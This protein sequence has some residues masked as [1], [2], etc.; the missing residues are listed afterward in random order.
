VPWQRKDDAPVVA[1]LDA[2]AFSAL[3]IRWPWLQYLAPALA[4]EVLDVTTFCQAGPQYDPPVTMGDIVWLGVPDYGRPF[5]ILEV[6]RAIARQEA[7][8]SYCENTDVEGEPVCTVPDTRSAWLAPPNDNMWYFEDIPPGYTHLRLSVIDDNGHP[9]GCAAIAYG[10]SDPPPANLGVIGAFSG[11]GSGFVGGAYPIQGTA[12]KFAVRCDPNGATFGV[13]WCN[14]GAG[15]YEPPEPVEDPDVVLPDG[16]G[17]TLDALEVKLDYIQQR[18]RGTPN[19]AL[20]PTSMSGVGELVDGELLDAVGVLVLI[21]DR[22][23]TRS[24][25][26]GD[27]P[28]YPGMAQ[29]T[30]G[31]TE[32]WWQHIDIEHEESVFLPLPHGATRWSVRCQPPM[33]ASVTLYRPTAGP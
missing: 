17:A 6:T 5:T 32:G 27:P 13:A 8:A 18:L 3:L 26:S 2:G 7:F 9:G 4:G 19:F 11:V 23:S 25:W 31:N 15:T 28:R 20:D 12:T 30:F 33:R 21:S 10:Y 1:V 22:P 16:T 24:E 29:L 14:I